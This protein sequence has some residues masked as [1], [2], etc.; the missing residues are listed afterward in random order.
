MFVYSLLKYIKI[1][2]IYLGFLVWLKFKLFVVYETYVVE[3]TLVLISF[4]GFLGW[5]CM[6][7]I[8][9]LKRNIILYIWKGNER[10]I[11]L[12]DFIIFFLEFDLVRDGFNF[13]F[14]YKNKNFFKNV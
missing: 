7:G 1:M 8:I 3:S 10:W 6:L 12:I 11:L 2:I 5:C 4:V 13:V 9:L 14:I